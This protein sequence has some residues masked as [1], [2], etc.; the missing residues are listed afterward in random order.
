MHRPSTPRPFDPVKSRRPAGSRPGPPRLALVI[1]SGGVRSIA[2]AGVAQVLQAAGLRPDLI[3][4]CS[5]GA[6]FGAAIATGAGS[7]ETLRAATDF[8]RPELT[9]QRRWRAYLQMLLPR[10]AGF[11]ADFS[12]RDDRLIAGTVHTAFGDL[13]LEELQTPLRVAAT[14]AASG[15]PVV[16]SRGPVAEAV[17]ASMALPFLFP[18][19]NVD[20][21]RLV[22]GVVSDPLPVSA[23]CDAQVVVALGFAGAMP[24]R[25]D[26]PSRLFAQA[27]TAL[28][29]NLMRARLDAARAAGQRVLNLELTLTRHVGLWQTD[30]LPYLFDAGVRL[31]QSRLPEIAALVDAAGA[32]GR[33]VPRERADPSVAA[34][35]AEP[36]EAAPTEPAAFRA[37]PLRALHELPHVPR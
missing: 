18:P 34:G 5:S 4:G 25:I 17:R 21:R 1:G 12:L 6:L 36:A 27:S 35:R 37:L 9:E 23:A 10:L 19:V 15:E 2:A 22:D 33:A 30:A 26:R 8:W 11:D 32:R 7:D 24:R 31:A 13:R 3:V 14:D 16:L 20:G 29:N 28:T